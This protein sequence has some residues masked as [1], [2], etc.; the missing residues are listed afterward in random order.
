MS[1]IKNFRYLLEVSRCR[2]ISEA[3]NHLFISQSQ[4]SRIIRSIEDEFNV[5]IFERRS[6]H[7]CPT[8]QGLT[9]LE[10]VQALV[11]DYDSLSQMNQLRTFKV[12]IQKFSYL[13]QGLTAFLNQNP[14]IHTL[15]IYETDENHIRTL[16]ASG[17]MQAGITHIQIQKR[18]LMLKEFTES[19][20]TYSR[21]WPVQ[22]AFIVRT[23]HPLTEKGEQLSVEEMYDYPL[24]ILDTGDAHSIYIGE[25]YAPFF[26][27]IDPE[28]FR[29]QILFKDFTSLYAFTDRSDAIILGHIAPVG[30]SA[31]RVTLPTSRL[32]E[33]ETT[34]FGVLFR[35]DSSPA[36]RKQVI[37]MIQCLRQPD[38]QK[39]PAERTR[40]D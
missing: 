32:I 35:R 21:L 15:K 11:N 20:L 9:F 1:D 26:Q 23:G 28:R 14:A 38:E 33:K 34:E 37:S 25:E 22:N 31:G 2:S 30:M 39:D 19:G 16:I 3:A 18:G 27:V 40:Q 6:G 29:Q 10:N 8:A 4:L 36:V 12:A 13:Y 17:E 5:M 24:A 7:I